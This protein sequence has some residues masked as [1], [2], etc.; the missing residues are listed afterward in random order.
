MNYYDERLKELHK[1]K[2]QKN[3]LE[4]TKTE[5]DA[6]RK[7]LLNKVA[8]LEKVKRKEQKD[9]DKIEGKGLVALFYQIAGN[10]EEKISKERREAYAAAMKYDAAKRELDGIEADLDYCMAELQKLADSEEEYTRLLEQKKTALKTSGD[11]RTKEIFALEEEL[12]SL[13]H[14]II[15]LEE[16]L[17]AGYAACDTAKQIVSELTEADDLA[18]W[19]IF[20]DSLLIDMSKREHIESAQNLVGDLQSQLRRF[21]TEL[22]DVQIQADIKIEI[23]DFDKFAD[24]F[25]DNIFTDWGIKEKI[26]NS[27]G[28]AKNTHTQIIQTINVLKDMRDTRGISRSQCQEKLEN[29]IVEL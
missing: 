5:L 14:E 26:E 9:V 2:S 15:E 11:A 20:A 29:L 10:K 13:E 27:L 12:A 28:Q 24:W 22:A 3:R 6:Q 4:T 7:N 16:A 19:D 21:K 1:Q 25:F 17:D 23:D 8:E 18:D